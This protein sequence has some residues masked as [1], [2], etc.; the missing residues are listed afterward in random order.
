MT[1]LD[2]RIPYERGEQLT[3]AH[4]WARAV[5]G[6]GTSPTART[7]VRDSWARSAGAHVRADLPFAPLVLADDS[8]ALER[9]R[10]DWLPFAFRA[11]DRLS[12]ALAEGHIL[13]LFDARGQMLAC[14]GDPHAR[15]GLAQI[16]FRPGG[17][18]T[19]D[20]V[21]TNGPGTALATGRAVHIV[22]A[23]HF[24]E[25]WHDWHCA[26]VPLRDE[27]TGE[28]LGVIDVSGFRRYAHP[29]TLEL[30]VALAT[31]VQQ[32]LTVRESER[33]YAVLHRLAELSAAHA[34]DA[35][36]AVDRGGRVLFATPATPAGLR[37]GTATPDVLRAAIAEHVRSAA[38]GGDP[39]EVMLAL[40]DDVGLTAM[41][42][43][44]LD[45]AT[46]VGACLLLRGGATARGRASAPA[47]PPASRA[48]RTTR[49]AFA[50][51][52][53]EA[54]ALREAVR[55]ARA[56]AANTLPVLLAGESGTGKEV[57]AQ[58]IH[59]A[60][61]RREH[62]FVA[63]NCAA[64]PRELVEAEL[65]GYVGGAFTGSRREGQ[66]GK[67]AAAEGGTIFLDEISEL[68][69]SA[70]AALLRIL[71]ERELTPVGSA[72]SR[73]IDV[74]VIA[75][76]NRRVEDAVATGQLRADLY[77][78]LNVLAIELPPLRERPGDVGPL[79]RHLLEL[80]MA[81]V[82]RFGLAFD[83][84]VLARFAA[85]G[86]PGNV[87]EL[88]NVV[89]RVAALAPTGLITEELLPESVRGGGAPA[90]MGSADDERARTVAAL[91]SAPTMAA[92]AARL[93][94]DRS[95][96]YRR[97]ERYGLTAKRSLGA[98]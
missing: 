65:F 23:E 88:K 1:S 4:T 34:G 33:R 85:Y 96:L 59:D 30:A 80:A 46:P 84:A 48:P 56:A 38:G 18:W 43:P 70:Q 35:L 41:S 57:F 28:L 26:A 61:A 79:A 83:D 86:W 39:R 92:A 95:T 73:A 45:G 58:A 8:L 98:R 22:G 27:I 17:L 49:Y 44:V 31:S 89:R 37:P 90:N 10:S 51:V 2:E 50:D 19:E 29:H 5:E 97:L 67:F 9:E 60:S 14:E 6:R 40:C 71:Q 15:E 53:G 16:N 91:E 21:G 20:A 36:V 66:G 3:L 82:G 24:C 76:T 25:A 32:M 42:H 7:L 75:A 77:Y 74:R 12:G 87:R 52:V 81:E 68:P 64:L 13:S 72:G 54:P 62:P 94:V 11:A 63:V 78:R 93:G 55:V 47:R 69:A